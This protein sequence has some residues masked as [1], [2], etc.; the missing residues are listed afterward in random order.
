MEL[1]CAVLITTH[2][3]RAELARTLSELRRLDPPPDEI[4]VC[5]DGCS[6]GTPEFVR[7]EHP[8]V[9]VLVHEPARGSI[10]SRNELAIACKSDIFL[11]LDDDSYPIERDFIARLRQLFVASPGLAVASFPQRS[12]EWPET[13]TTKDFGASR[14]VG[15]YANSGAALRSSVFRELGGYPEF[16]FHAYEEPDFAL[17][18]LATGW[19]VRYETGLSIRHHFTPAQRDER[20]THQR[21]ARNEFWS[22][23]LRCPAPQLFAVAAF[24]AARQFKYASQR[25]FRWALAEPRWWVAALAGIPRCL[26]RREPLPWRI[27][28]AWMRLVRTPVRSIEEWKALFGKA[29]L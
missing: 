21:H 19:Q 5:A 4:L 3:R 7:A 14:F 17:R 10:P 22:V 29:V 1:S 15:S 28:L 12:D 26:A 9:R 2:N 16:F 23:L 27:Y 6:D 24:R 8:E 18:C 13:L 20:R 11:S 25:G